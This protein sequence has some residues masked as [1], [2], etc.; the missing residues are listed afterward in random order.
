MS[1][2]KEVFASAPSTQEVY[3]DLN[4]CVCFNT[5]NHVAQVGYVVVQDGEGYARP[6]SIYKSLCQAWQVIED[7]ADVDS[8]TCF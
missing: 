3:H 7:E 2:L 4:G 1:Y 6:C 8:I 5:V